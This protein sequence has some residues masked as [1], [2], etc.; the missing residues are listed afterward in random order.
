MRSAD[1][2]VAWVLQLCPEDDGEQGET[3][4]GGESHVNVQQHGADE[5]DHPDHLVERRTGNT[6]EKDQINYFES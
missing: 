3:D 5:G 6:R 2:T 4:G 1:L